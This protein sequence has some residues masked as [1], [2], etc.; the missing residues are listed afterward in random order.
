MYLMY[1]CSMKLLVFVHTSVS[2]IQMLHRITTV[3]KVVRFCS[4]VSIPSLP[5]TLFHCLIHAWRLP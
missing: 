3:T 2:Y 4:L 5:F 1:F